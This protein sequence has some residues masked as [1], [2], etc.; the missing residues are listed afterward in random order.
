MKK[1]T[2]NGVLLSFQVMRYNHVKL[3]Y[4]RIFGHEFQIS[5]SLIFHL[6]SN[7]HF[8]IRWDGVQNA[9]INLRK[10]G[11]AIILFASLWYSSTGVFSIYSTPNALSHIIAN[12]FFLDIKR[13]IL[14]LMIEDICTLDFC[15]ACESFT[16]LSRNVVSIFLFDVELF[17]LMSILHWSENIVEWVSYS[18]ALP[19]I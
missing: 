3:I 1:Y 19:L 9:I 7:D 16:C 6:Q 5:A 11:K 12:T 2:I 10:Y 18:I 15:F 4:L 17:F 14:P 13:V 8:I